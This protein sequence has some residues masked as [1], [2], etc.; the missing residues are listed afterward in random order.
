MSSG[1]SYK[2]R[3]RSRTPVILLLILAA[4][5]ILFYDSNTRL[6][7]EEYEIY[8][9][10]LPK[11]FDG[12]RV[13]QLSDLH[14]AVFGNE[15][16]ELLDAVRK[17]RPDIIAVTGDLIDGDMAD[18]YV[19]TLMTELCGIAP[20]YYVTGNHEWASGWIRE[21]FDILE[22]CGVKV[23]RN[24]Y[25]LLEKDREAIVLAGADDPNGPYDMMTHTELVRKIQENEGRR[26]VLM[27]YHRNENLSEWEEL[28][29]DT[30]LCGHAHGGVIRLPFTDGLI[31]PDREWFPE[32]TSGLHSFGDT[33]VLISRGLGNTPNTLRLLNNPE[34]TVAVLRTD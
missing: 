4:A 18:D 11:S 14:T 5:A 16:E 7:T 31:S 19:R 29:V 8:D 32:I 23:L 2:K 12:L 21:L 13:V 20:V 30:V 17:A 15:N 25:I 1:M 34:I 10:D 26:Y 27:L 24:E 9:A 22:E 3:R 6:V 28:G 33:S